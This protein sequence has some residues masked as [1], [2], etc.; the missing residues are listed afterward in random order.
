MMNGLLQGGRWLARRVPAVRRLA[1]QVRRAVLPSSTEVGEIMP[2][3]PVASASQRPRLNL[4]V[5]AVSEEH[6]FGGINTALQLF[7]ALLQAPGL[8]SADARIVITDDSSGRGGRP[9]GALA[10]WPL[11]ANDD[12]EGRFLQGLGPSRQWPLPVRPQDIFIATTW[13]SAFILKDV[14]Q[15]QQQQYAQPA[16]PWAYLIQD[17]EPGFYA[18]GSRYWLAQTTYGNATEPDPALHAVIN[19]PSLASFLA[20][21]GHVFR[22]MRWFDPPLHPSL[23]RD[24]KARPVM[25]KERTILVY[26]RPGVER[27]AFPLVLHALRLWAQQYPNAAAWQVV[28]A[29]EPH[30]PFA[31]GS[32]QMLQ[33]LGKLSLEEYTAWLRRA[34]VGLSLMC[35]P[36][37]SY[38]PRDMAAFEIDTV[39][40]PF[41]DK[42][43]LDHPRFRPAADP[44]PHALAQTLGAATKA[45]DAELSAT[46]HGSPEAGR[47]VVDL[48]HA[49]LASAAPFADFAPALAE[50]LLSP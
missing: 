13:W 45:F 37:P 2:L 5:P 47:R 49:W 15:W 9:S 23:Q 6:R 1:Q 27:N 36:H 34:S 48:N 42:P 14:R 20:R 46:G 17:Y 26:G 43:M 40:L 50:Q 7:E 35:S 38:P 30:A 44:T 25:A 10:G 28:S 19:S 31:L 24:A 8:Q 16:R 22:H 11:H 32:G 21:Q 4:L 18:W 29:G 33:P 12:A 41:A 39:T 3:H